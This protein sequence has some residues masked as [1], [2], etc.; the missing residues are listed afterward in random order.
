MRPRATADFTL[1]SA[2]GERARYSS[3]SEDGSQVAFMRSLPACSAA[4]VIPGC[5]DDPDQIISVAWSSTP[6]LTGALQRDD[7]NLA[8]GGVVA[9]DHRAPVLSGSGRYV[10]WE[11]QGGAVL[12]GDPGFPDNFQVVMRQRD[13]GLTVG[14]V[15]FG[16]QAA[17]TSAVRT[18]T[19][20]NTGRSSILPGEIVTTSPSFVVTGGTCGVG[21]WIAPG[22]TCTV[23]V[24][25]DAAAQCGGDQRRADRART[26][27]Q[28]VSA[29]GRL[30]ATVT[31]PPS[32]TLPP[33]TLP[34]ITVPPPTTVAP[35]VVLSATPDPLDFGPVAIGI[36]TAVLEVTV[37]NSGNTSGP[38]ALGITGD[39]ASD[40]EIVSDSCRLAPLAPGSTCLVRI[41]MLPSAGGDRAATLGVISTGSSATV[42]LVGQGRLAPQLVASPA[43]ITERGFTTV[44]GQGFIPGEAVTVDVISTT[45]AT[46]VLSLP[47]VVDAA[48]LL[49]VPLA[50]FGQLSLGSY[51]LV[52]AAR[53]DAYDEVRATLLVA[54]GTFQPQG[55]TSIIFGD[56]LLVARGN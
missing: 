10:A 56:N 38:I 13:V 50:S 15:P 17:G 30:T 11:T 28:A 20:T 51:D 52:V 9:S 37:A 45:T 2:V 23:D 21:A 12:L 31:V 53:P 26:G 1:V 35:T 39:H 29:S 6:G 3:I 27:F 42:G 24:R 14:D 19:V 55:P 18:S 48:G 22:A 40:F 54:L 32:T 44:V 25:F 16:S 8:A 5:V 34:P 46:V 47:T 7:V 49:Q 33:T 36:P 4:A 41:R 43:S